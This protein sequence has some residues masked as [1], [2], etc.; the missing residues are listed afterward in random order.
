MPE[1]VKLPPT[2]QDGEEWSQS[3]PRA[4]PAPVSGSGHLTEGVMRT[5]SLKV[6][7]LIVIG[8]IV[9][10][11]FADVMAALATSATGNQ[12]PDLT[13]F[14]SLSSSGVDLDRATVGD[15]VTET[16]SVTNNTSRKQAVKLVVT[17]ELPDGD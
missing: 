13:V 10:I 7:A 6:K 1:R 11:G 2:R 5:N 17:L 14:V 16:V 4:N 9:G 8:I 3:A 12:N 15:T